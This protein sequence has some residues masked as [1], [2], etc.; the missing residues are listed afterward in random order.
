MN[1]RLVVCIAAAALAFTASAQVTPTI[2]THAGSGTPGPGP[3]G[4]PSGNGGPATQSDLGYALKV[5]ADGQGNVY[6]LDFGWVFVEEA[7]QT[8]QYGSVFVRKVD[9]ATGLITTVAGGGSSAPA[10]GM[11]ATDAFFQFGWSLASDHDGN[12]F[13]G[14]F[15]EYP[16]VNARIWRIDASTGILTTYAGGVEPTMFYPLGEC[17]GEVAPIPFPTGDGGPATAAVIVGIED[18]AVDPAGNLHFCDRSTI[19]KIDASTGIISVV[20]GTNAVSF[21][22]SNPGDSMC[23]GLKLGVYSGDG[24]PATSAT[25]VYPVDIAFDSQGNLFI[26]EYPDLS[27]G[28]TNQRIRRVD[29]TTGVITAYAGNGSVGFSGDGGP[30]IAASLNLT[31]GLA[32]DSSDNLYFADSG[33]GVVRRVNAATGNISTVVGTPGTFGF[34]GD[35]GPALGSLLSTAFDMAMDADGNL[36]I[37]DADNYRVRKVVGLTNAP[38]TAVAGADQAIHATTLITLD[39]SA[40]FDDNT[41]STALTYSWS[42]VSRP[43]GSASILFT[44]NSPTCQ[45]IPDRVGTFAVQLVVYDEA[46][47]PSEPDVVYISSTNMAPTADAGSTAIALVCDLVWLD[48]SASSDPEVDPLTYQWTMVDS[49]RWS[50]TQLFYSTTATPVFFADR[51]GMYSFRLVVNDGFGPSAPDTV[52]I[53]VITGAEYAEN[54]IQQAIATIEALPASQVTNRGNKTALL[55]LLS[56]AIRSLQNGNIANACKQIEDALDRVDGCVERGRPD[57]SGNSRDWVLNCTAQTSVYNNLMD[58]LEAVDNEC[59]Y[60]NRRRCR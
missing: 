44:P 41:L 17:E 36:F 51:P 25:L 48:G 53:T 5:A 30:A 19:R 32:L 12:V 3:D 13:F 57:P 35:G 55:N 47:L 14:E 6:F 42:F 52:T 29:T 1:H 40:S 18:M 16:I 34:G 21:V 27:G 7:D 45:F 39:G 46:G 49:P 8:N 43:A 15:Y 23:T 38:P 59:R 28:P 20:A 2:S 33:N 11:Q 22:D 10:D 54:L 50:C 9:V 60:H 4:G 31:R 26:A 58:A 56:H 24:G 37:A